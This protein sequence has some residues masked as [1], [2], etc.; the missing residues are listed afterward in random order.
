[1]I[2]GTP[3]ATHVARLARSFAA[4]FRAPFLSALVWSRT[5]DTE[6]HLGKGECSDADNHSGYTSERCSGGPRPPH[7]SRAPKPFTL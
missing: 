6:T 3:P 1:V 7:E 4:M 5:G 2:D